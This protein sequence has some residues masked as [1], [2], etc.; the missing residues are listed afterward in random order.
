MFSCCRP[1]RTN[2]SGTLHHITSVWMTTE[3]P[4]QTKALSA[5]LHCFDV[6]LLSFCN[7]NLARCPQGLN[8]HLTNTIA[9]RIHHVP[10]QRSRNS[11]T[12]WGFAVYQVCPAHRCLSLS[13]YCSKCRLLTTYRDGTL[14]TSLT[15]VK[16]TSGKSFTVHTDLLRYWSPKMCLILKN[17]STELNVEANDEVCS[18][19]IGWLYMQHS[20]PLNN[21]RH[22]DVESWD[23]DIEIEE[24]EELEDY[25]RF[26]RTSHGSHALD[27]YI[28]ATRYDIRQLKNDAID[29]LVKNRTCILFPYSI[30]IKTFDMLSRGS[31]FLEF[32]V[33][34]FAR[35]YKIDT[36]NE[37]LELV[38]RQRLP[39]SFLVSS[40]LLKKMEGE[41]K[42]GDPL[43]MCTITSMLVQREKTASS[44]T[45]LATSV[46]RTRRG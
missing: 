4:H 26:Y 42:V 12:T 28:F 27:V 34:A 43:N 3:G 35:Y 39:N 2:F 25:E 29:A 18:A 5:P 37:R 41:C 15:C 23:N 17:E 46:G 30:V 11:A 8:H 14:G 36:D 10:V 33:A 31:P 16:I 44:H 40:L 9:V 38:L 19:F 13:C 1:L 45:L 22:D 20:P 6:H 32:L 21:Y 24:T 7:S